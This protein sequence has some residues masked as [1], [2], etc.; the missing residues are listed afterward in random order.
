VSRTL[1]CRCCAPR[2]LKAHDARGADMC[3][4]SFERVF[5]SG[6]APMNGRSTGCWKRPLMLLVTLAALGGPIYLYMI[7]REGFFRRDTGFLIGVT[8]AATDP[9]F[10]AMKVRQQALVAVLNPTTGGSLHH[11]T[12]GAGGPNTTALRGRAVRFVAA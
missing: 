11:S 12:V 2:M 10:E 5:D 7:V 3:V 9:S 6:F 8:E 1:N 4:A